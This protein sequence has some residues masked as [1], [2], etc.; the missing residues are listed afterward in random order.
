VNHRLERLW[1]NWLDSDH[2][3]QFAKKG[4]GA[5][6]FNSRAFQKLDT[7]RRFAI[8]S[9]KSYRQPALFHNVQTFCM[10]V[11]HVKS[12][13]TLIGSLLDAHPHIVLADEID[14][15]YYVQAGFKKEQIYHLLLKGSQ[16]EALKGRV[17][18]RRLTPYS[19]AVPGQWQGRYQKLKV[20]GD[21][22]A[23]PSTRR[24]GREPELS[25][26]VKQVMAGVDL[27]FIQVIRNPYDPISAMIMRGRR[28][29]ENAIDHYFNYCETLAAFRK[30]VPDFGS[31]LA[32]RYEDFVGQPKEHLCDLCHFL[33][34]E[35]NDTYLDACAGIVRTSPDQYRHM[36]TWSPHWIGVVHDRIDQFDFLA[37][38]TYEN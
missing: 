31:L 2:L 17:T 14:A 30:R 19:L 4:S 24:L 5:W 36:V 35:A 26:H 10:F 15:L 23:G 38:Y 33:G 8:T 1:V 25:W 21:S 11:G 34:V 6:L 9:Y 37:G 16:R 12:G 13:G 20:I 28:T 27:R 22:K 3:R 7:A 32:V 18:A 29:F